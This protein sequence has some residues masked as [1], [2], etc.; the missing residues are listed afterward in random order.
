MSQA[1]KSLIKQLIVVDWQKRLPARIALEH[2][3][4]TKGQPHALSETK[5]GLS[6]A[7]MKKWRAR[8]RLRA[9]KDV[10]VSANFMRRLTGGDKKGDTASSGPLKAKVVS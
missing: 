6:Q 9:A 10:V 3:W 2:P 1:A 7:Q 8:K 5:L 4:F